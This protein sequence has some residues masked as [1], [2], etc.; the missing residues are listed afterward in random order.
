MK[1]TKL[2]ASA[3]ALLTLASCSQDVDVV[4]PQEAPRTRQVHIDLTAGQDANALRVTYGLDSDGKTT[5]LLM[6]DKNVILRVAVRRASGETVVQDLEFTKTP[7]RNHATYTGQITIPNTGS[8]D[9]TISA[10]L[11]KEAGTGG[12]V[13]GRDLSDAEATREP[14]LR[15]DAVVKFGATRLVAHDTQT[16]EANIPYVSEWQSITINSTV[17]E[18]VTLQMRP[19]GTL[20]RMRIKNESPIR[21]TFR[22]IRLGTNAMAPT[23]DFDLS[24][25]RDTYPY[26]SSSNTEVIYLPI[27][28]NRLVGGNAGAIT[29]ITVEP[30]E[31]SPWMYTIVYPRKTSSDIVTIASLDLGTSTQSDFRKAFR[32]TLPLP[33]GS[34]PMT[35]TYTDEHGAEFEDLV[36]Y[37]EWGSSTSRPKLAIEYVATHS[38]TQAGNAFVADHLTSNTDIGRFTSIQMLALPSPIV[39]DGTNYYIP[40]RDEMLSIFPHRLDPLSGHQVENTSLALT[41]YFEPNVKIGNETRNYVSD[42]FRLSADIS[43][44]LY[45]IRFKR[46]KHCTA[47]RYRA[48]DLDGAVGKGLLVECIYLGATTDVTIAN[49]AQE[50][51]WTTRQAEI[52]SRTFPFYGEKYDPLASSVETFNAAGSYWTSSQH[53]PTSFYVA[54]TGGTQPLSFGFTTLKS[55][56]SILPIRPFT[57]D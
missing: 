12:K 36:D 21:R 49:V 14:S 17:A 33:H 29:G 40:T 16:I 24:R 15:R 13:Y 41:N 31:Y 8:G 56:R 55:E 54:I 1:L 22:S 34:V 47:Y 26:W 53:D 35:L 19:F 48:V 25:T 23:V 46:T 2:W 3:L 37:D 7:D 5:G 51:F 30:S 45:A 10:V 18:P 57:R 43:N 44:P 39:I 9:Y 20:L 27:N 52:V 4:Q 42:Y 28:N 6:S 32:T 38:L 11:L 50:S